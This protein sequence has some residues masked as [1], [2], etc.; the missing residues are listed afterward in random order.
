MTFS[1][2]K[3]L[4]LHI[5]VQQCETQVCGDQTSAGHGCAEG[6]VTDAPLPAHCSPRWMAWM[7]ILHHQREALPGEVWANVLLV[8]HHTRAALH[9][10]EWWTGGDEEAANPPPLHSQNF[11]NYKKKTNT[12]NYF[13]CWPHWHHSLSSGLPQETLQRQRHLRWQQTNELYDSALIGGV[14]CFDL[15]MVSL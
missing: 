3:G 6:E 10:A 2:G 14:L 11:K 5:T 7:I 8:H 15:W 9:A 13:T 12:L 4:I 1:R